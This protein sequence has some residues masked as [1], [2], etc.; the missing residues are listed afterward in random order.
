MRHLAVIPTRYEPER[1]TALVDLVWREV[2]TLIV[3][4]NGHEEPLDLPEQVR[5]VDTRG[6]AIYRQWNKAWATAVHEGYDYLTLLNDDIRILE[7]TLP[8][9]LDAL[10][11]RPSYGVVYPDKYV[12][13]SVGL[14]SEPTFDVVR[15]PY[16]ERT[17]TGFAFTSRVSMFDEP[18]FDEGF[19]W[20]AGDDAFDRKVRVAGFAVAR[21]KG[22]PI[23]HESDSERNGWARRPELLHLAQQDLARWNAM[24]R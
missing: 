19:H 4:D 13:L 2:S 9:L 22:L 20:W 15:S 14:P 7:G 10:A 8:L 11:C 23:E 17:L 18:P 21:Y 1:V 3:M 16:P 6:D 12:P 24:S 5:V